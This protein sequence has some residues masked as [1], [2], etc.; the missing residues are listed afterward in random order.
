MPNL[1][2]QWRPLFSANYLDVQVAGPDPARGAGAARETSARVEQA[3]T[4]SVR[5]KG[6]P[7]DLR[8]HAVPSSADPIVYPVAGSR[9]R[10]LGGHR[11]ARASP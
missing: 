9:S 3:L 4:R 10:A 6:C 11:A 2:T 1:G 7:A 5:T 8:A